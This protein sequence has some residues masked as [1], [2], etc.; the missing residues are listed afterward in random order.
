M[1]SRLGACASYH[2][3]PFD[4][5]VYETIDSKLKTLA[6]KLPLKIRGQSRKRG[7]SD[8]ISH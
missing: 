5:T 7:G 3:S 8:D 6:G 1:G 2:V 4:S